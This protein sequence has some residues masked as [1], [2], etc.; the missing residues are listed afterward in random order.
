MQPGDT[1]IDDT[2]FPCR[3]N[4]RIIEEYNGCN[5]CLYDGLSYCMRP[6]GIESA[7]CDF[8]IIFEDCG[9]VDGSF[10]LEG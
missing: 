1:F 6:Q 8:G 3:H 2:T 9:P 5:G 7:C 10:V 4:I